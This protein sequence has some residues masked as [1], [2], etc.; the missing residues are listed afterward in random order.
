M[1]QVF[2]IYENLQ[3]TLQKRPQKL[4]LHLQLKM[5]TAANTS[6]SDLVHTFYTLE[7]EVFAAATQ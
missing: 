4:N 6:L 7:R 1:Q 3:F 5:A 2:P